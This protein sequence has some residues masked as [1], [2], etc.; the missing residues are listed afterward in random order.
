MVGEHL[1]R[2]FLPESGE[3]SAGAV[4][5]GESDDLFGDDESA[6]LGK[7]RMMKRTEHFSFEPDTTVGISV[8]F[9]ESLLLPLDRGL[10][11]DLES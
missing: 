5:D 11:D 1:F 9:A 10:G 6:K 3:I 7:E 2:L 8:F 4:I